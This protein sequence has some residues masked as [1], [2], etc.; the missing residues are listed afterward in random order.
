[1]RNPN[2]RFHLCPRL[3]KEFQ[4]KCAQLALKIS[5]ELSIFGHARS[6]LRRGRG[7]PALLRLEASDKV[8]ANAPEG[9][10][11]Q[12]FAPDRF[13][14]AREALND[15]IDLSHDA[16]GFL[17]ILPLPRQFKA[18]AAPAHKRVTV[19]YRL[20]GAAMRQ[21]IGRAARDGNIA[22]LAA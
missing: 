19:G 18:I 22:S 2:V 9:L 5:R 7:L 8:V 10:V 20:R 4:K 15:E 1:M 13:G 17:R 16:S 11:C 21:M 6:S 3:A 14:K 12:I